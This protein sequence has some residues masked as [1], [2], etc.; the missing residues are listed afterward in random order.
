MVSA[1]P[2]VAN[3]EC[4]GRNAGCDNGQRSLAVTSAVL[5]NNNNNNNDSDLKYVESTAETSDKKTII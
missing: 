4:G 5:I 1:W 3:S 2:V